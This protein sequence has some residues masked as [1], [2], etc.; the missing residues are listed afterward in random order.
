MHWQSITS[1]ASRNMTLRPRR[2]DVLA[3]LCSVPL[4]GRAV[5]AKAATGTGADANWPQYQRGASNTGYSPALGFEPA[6]LA[7]AWSG[8]AG[9]VRSDPLI[10]DGTLYVTGMQGTFAYDLASGERLWRRSLSGLWSPAYAD[11]TLYVAPSWE[12]Y[13]R[14]LDP[15]TGKDRWRFDTSEYADRRSRW[16]ANQNVAV[17]DG[18]VVVPGMTSDSA[19]L[20]AL[21]TGSGDVRWI[22]ESERSFGSAPAIDDGTVYVSGGFVDRREGIHAYALA[23]ASQRWATP[24]KTERGGVVVANGR[25]YGIDGHDP[26]VFALDASNG[27]EVWR[28]DDGPLSGADGLESPVVTDDAVVVGTR[29]GTV[30]SVDAASGEVDWTFDAGGFDAH[31]WASTAVFGD[32]VLVGNPS[33]DAYALDAADGS[34]L[35]S[36]S[37]DRRVQCPPV[38]TDSLVVVA[39]DYEEGDDETFHV[40]RSDLPGFDLQVR[41]GGSGRV[42]PGGVA[43]LHV[44]PEHAGERDVSVELRVRTDDLGGDWPLVRTDDF[45]SGPPPTSG[46]FRVSGGTDPMVGL[47]SA[48]LRVPA[49][50]TG[51]VTVRAEAVDADTGVTYATGEATL[52]V[53]PDGFD[54]RV[55]GFGFVNFGPDAPGHDH[56]KLSPT[57]VL[58]I[59]GAWD[60]DSVTAVLP[61]GPHV[62]LPVLGMY[63]VLE[64]V[65]DAHCY[66]MCLTATA[67][68]DVD[69]PASEDDAETAIDIDSPADPLGSRI[70]EAQQRQNFDLGT[71]LL[72]DHLMSD[73]EIDDGGVLDRIER[74]V[75]ERGTAMVALGN[76]GETVG[77]QLAAYWYTESAADDGSDETVVYVY[78][79]NYSFARHDPAQDYA[80]PGGAGRSDPESG[81]RRLVF[82]TSGAD[83]TFTGYRL[84]AD[85]TYER[86]VHLPRD[87]DYD[88][89]AVVGAAVATGLSD[90]L[91]DLGAGATGLASRALQQVDG[92]RGI[93][94]VG[95]RSPVDL[96]VTGPDGEALPEA[97]ASV[98]EGTDYEQVRFGY[99]V[100]PGEYAVELTGTGSGEYTLETLGVDAAG[101]VLEDSRTGTIT[102]GETRDATFRLGSADGTD[103]DGNR[104]R[105]DDGGETVTPDEGDGGDPTPT[106]TEGDGPLPTW[107]SLAGLGGGVAAARRLVGSGA[108]DTDGDGDSDAGHENAG[109]G[110]H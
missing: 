19:R 45:W 9:N 64:R 17:A 31:R 68:Y 88:P 54:P 70:D 57:E 75:D 12:R 25:V 67:F 43:D 15:A 73:R 3:A 55:H 93:L 92:V 4:L 86:A 26:S 47:P 51:A 42:V 27:E 85:T 20:F 102:E 50:A 35:W 66:G 5:S 71:F 76:A 107:L 49:D 106:S 94:A 63:A 14:A 53:D 23:D 28:A 39:T 78:D 18:T 95:V 108:D 16:G 105:T 30:V 40:Y 37:F 98:V 74:D 44:V 81:Y 72:V 65:N 99:D 1:E 33:G 110:P 96:A 109:D 48:R 24:V 61:T 77:H 32:V 91:A 7:H 56:T 97:P 21:D 29:D 6:D 34:V 58:G 82:E 10:V 83:V 87:P 46:G 62:V 38:A 103:G 79:P 52:S 69:A 80:V 104:S 90:A 60:A 84:D 11:G 100:P 59:V 101:G 13:V 41:P 36:A 2:R 89:A 22:V 8:Y